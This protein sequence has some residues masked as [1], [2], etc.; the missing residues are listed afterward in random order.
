MYLQYYKRKRCF[1]MN[2]QGKE[3]YGTHGRIDFTRLWEYLKIRG[4]NKQWLKDR[5]IHSN[6]IAKMVK[7]ENVSC[8]VLCRLCDILN[9]RLDEIAEYKRIQ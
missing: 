9:C 5:H 4:Y 7:N 2:N 1:T 6:T 3:P 8:D